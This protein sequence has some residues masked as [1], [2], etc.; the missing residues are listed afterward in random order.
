MGRPVC[1]WAQMLIARNQSPPWLRVTTVAA[2][3]LTVPC[4]VYRPTEP[5]FT[6]GGPQ[7]ITMTGTGHRNRVPDEGYPLCR[8]NDMLIHADG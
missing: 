3:R 5:V 1:L 8:V 4:I 2:N 7:A 6:A